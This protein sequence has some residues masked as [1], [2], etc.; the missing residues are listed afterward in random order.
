MFLQTELSSGDICSFQGL[1]RMVNVSDERLYNHDIFRV[2]SFCHIRPT[3]QPWKKGFMKVNKKALN[4][5][6]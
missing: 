2:F 4:K 5:V 3:L 1:A 6:R